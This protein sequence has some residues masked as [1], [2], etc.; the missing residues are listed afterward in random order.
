MIIGM[1][2]LNIILEM[3]RSKSCCSGA[4]NPGSGPIKC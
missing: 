3:G 4:K 2:K 1:V